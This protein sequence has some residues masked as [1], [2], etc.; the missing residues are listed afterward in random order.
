MIMSFGGDRSLDWERKE[1]P[2]AGSPDEP[3]S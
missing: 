2:Q 1:F 3:G